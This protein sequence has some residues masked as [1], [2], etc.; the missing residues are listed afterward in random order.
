MNTPEHRVDVYLTVDSEIWPSEIGNDALDAAAIRAEFPAQFDFYALG[1][2]A[3]GD[4]GL[5]YQARLLDRYGLKATFF[6]ETLF[7]EIAGAQW[8]RDAV[9]MVRAQGHDVQLHAHTE[10]LGRPEIEALPLPR[11]INLHEYALEDQVRIL[12]RAAQLL[13]RCG[14]AR[15][16]AFRAGNFGAGFDTLTALARARIAIDSSY[17]RAYVPDPCAL[18]FEAPLTAP[19]RVN[20]VTEYPVAFFHSGRSVRPA[21]LVACSLRELTHAL[22][23]AWAA[24][25]PAFVIVWHSRELLHPRQRATETARVHRLVVRRLEGLARYL[26]EHAARFDCRLFSTQRAANVPDGVRSMPVIHSTAL[27]TAGRL[28]EAAASRLTRR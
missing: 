3:E 1:R 21:H 19:V 28:V 6:Q 13:E 17:N 20:G 22:D 14:V 5:G 18:T 26:A 23:T 8:L 15:P 2:T 16:L 4:F 24:R 7:S 27:L 9:E 10:W 25:W 11:R 12:E